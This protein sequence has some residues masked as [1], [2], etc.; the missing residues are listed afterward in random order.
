MTN[1]HVSGNGQFMRI[2]LLTVRKIL[3]EVS[4]RHPKRDV[5]IIQVEKSGN[6]PIPI[7]TTPLKVTE[8]VYAIG[9]PRKKKLAGTVTRGIVSKFATN[10]SGMEDIQADVDI[11]GGNSVGPLLDG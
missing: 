6:L 10:R 5:A 2:Q 4:R 3:G 7:R 9:S 8:E 11:Q 1:V